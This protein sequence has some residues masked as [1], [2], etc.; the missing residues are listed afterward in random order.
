MLLEM[1]SLQPQISLS[2]W[3]GGQGG[4]ET[5]LAPKGQSNPQEFKPG[6]LTLTTEPKIPTPKILPSSH[7]S[8]PRWRRS[9]EP[10]GKYT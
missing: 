7:A 9:R 10:G 4:W 2:G 8:F 6:E 3:K 5:L 1:D